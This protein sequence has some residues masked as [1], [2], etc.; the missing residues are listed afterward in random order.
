MLTQITN[1]F[2]AQQQNIENMTNKSKGDYAYTMLDITSDY[3]P[4]VQAAIEAIDGVV[5]VCKFDY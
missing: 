1:A 5:R 4:E 2:A 3:S